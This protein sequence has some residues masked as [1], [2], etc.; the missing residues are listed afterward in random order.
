MEYIPMIIE[1]LD[2]A[3]FSTKF[4][5]YSLAIASVAV[6]VTVLTLRFSK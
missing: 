3:Q 4:C 1:T 6:L 2:K 5:F